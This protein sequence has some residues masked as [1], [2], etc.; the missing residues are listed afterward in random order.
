[1]D[2]VENQ[3]RQ[4]VIGPMVEFHSGIHGSLVNRAPNGI[5]YLTSRGRVHYWH[6]PDEA[7][8]PLR[9]M[10]V[11]EVVELEPV[12]PAS[13]HIIHTSRVPA[14]G[15]VPWLADVD[16][17]LATLVYGRDFMFGLAEE[18]PAHWSPELS[19]LRVRKMVRRFLAP[20]CFGLY[21]HTHAFR[22]MFMNF[23][24]N[25]NLF[26]VQELCLLDSR[27]GVFLPA[28]ETMPHQP[29]AQGRPLRVCYSARAGLHKGQEVAV[30]VF[31][32][33]RA[34]LG[35]A[36]DLYWVGDEPPVDVS[37]V[38]TIVPLL[39]RHDYL[40]F[41]RD[42]DIYFSPSTSETLGMAMLEA[43][44]LGAV[45]VCGHA[46]GMPHLDELFSDDVDGVVIDRGLRDQRIRDYVSR[47]SA[48][49]KDDERLGRLSAAALDRATRN[50]EARDDLLI[51]RYDEM[52]GRWDEVTARAR[53][54]P[55]DGATGDGFVKSSVD[56][57]L[58][59]AVHEKRN[60]DKVM[61]LTFIGNEVKPV[62]P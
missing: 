6:E 19:D 27:C 8:S 4:V 17:A 13:R 44:A 11:D 23:A 49:A 16:S 9:C 47:I 7:W 50:L 18:A 30:E 12:L 29:R 54:L 36:I 37:D 15:S 26:D 61:H 3:L 55:A 58:L 59:A 39:T 34:V 51:E 2:D 62:D 56:L 33:L 40:D 41:I 52:F 46:S 25:S 1:M 60:Q 21:F 45:V 32:E 24:D 20:E 38:A 48:I 10:A 35:E 57:D 43:A 22:T 5:R 42:C 28:V 31:R 14:H 53:G